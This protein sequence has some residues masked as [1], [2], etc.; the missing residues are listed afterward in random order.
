MPVQ[1]VS[2]LVFMMQKDQEVC[3]ETWTH[4]DSNSWSWHVKSHGTYN[5][6][7]HILSCNRQYKA[8]SLSQLGEREMY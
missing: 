8:C 5:G 6:Y 7:G 2:E 4:N 1:V 3:F